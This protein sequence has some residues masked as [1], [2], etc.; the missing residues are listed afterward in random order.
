MSDRR[1]TVRPEELDDEAFIAFMANV[2]MYTLMPAEWQ[3]APWK[4]ISRLVS[5]GI[6]T[7]P[8]AADRLD[9]VARRAIQACKDRVDA[10]KQ[11]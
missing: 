5:M 11:R 4:P 7:E 6:I 1:I 10:G 8:S 2:K 3:Y 9:D